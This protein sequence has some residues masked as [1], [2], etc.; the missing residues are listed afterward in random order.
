MI[1]YALILSTK[2]PG[3]QWTLNGDN[4]DGLVWLD[5]T[6]QPYKAVIVVAVECPL[7]AG[8]IG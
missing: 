2:Y 8:V 3:A 6:A 1:D 4:Y 5:E 7:C